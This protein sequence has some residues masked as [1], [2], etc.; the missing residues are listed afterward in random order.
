MMSIAGHELF[1]TYRKWRTYIGFLALGAVVP[2]VEI[3]MKLG[4]PPGTVASWLA[5]AK[6][7]LR[8]LLREE[9]AP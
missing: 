6:A 2:L 4:A 1:K 5:R 9:G 3:G 7:Q 8:L